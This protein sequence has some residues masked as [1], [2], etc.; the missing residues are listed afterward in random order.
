MSI[1]IPIQDNEKPGDCSAALPFIVTEG[2]AQIPTGHHTPGTSKTQQ[3]LRPSRMQINDVHFMQTQ[4][5]G[6]MR[7]YCMDPHE[8]SV[9]YKYDYKLL[10]EKL[11]WQLYKYIRQRERNMSIDTDNK[12]GDKYRTDTDY[13]Y[14][15][16]QATW[17]ELMRQDPEPPEA[18]PIVAV[19]H[20]ITSVTAEA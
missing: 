8:R 18:D 7:Q 14:R 20:S 3:G 2:G 6:L 5:E 16:M 17:Q 1:T 10:L 11:F 19:I 9:Q 4:L 12:L 15:C 13:F